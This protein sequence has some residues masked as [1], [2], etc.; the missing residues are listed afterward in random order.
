VSLQAT[1]FRY[2]ND[3]F[4]QDDGNKLSDHNPV[5]VEFSWSSS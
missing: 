2:P 3:I 4:I 1:S 5:L